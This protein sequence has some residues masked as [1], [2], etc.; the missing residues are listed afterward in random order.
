MQI[1]IDIPDDEYAFIKETG[2]I[3]MSS[4]VRIARAIANGIV[5]PKGH[6]RLIDGD[7]IKY[8]NNS[9]TKTQDD[10]CVRK[11]DIDK[12]PTIIEAD[13]EK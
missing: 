13:K 10:W 11:D 9:W 3:K 4:D 6:G 7:N 8:F 2:V 12:M 5:L 1:V